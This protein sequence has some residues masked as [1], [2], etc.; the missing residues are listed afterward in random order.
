MD[1]ITIT[2]RI[3]ITLRSIANDGVRK[4][5]TDRLGV[6]CTAKLMYKSP[7]LSIDHIVKE[8]SAIDKQSKLFDNVTIVDMPS[9]PSQSHTIIFDLEVYDKANEAVW[10]VG[11]SM[12]AAPRSTIAHIA[13]L[14]HMSHAMGDRYPDKDWVK[15]GVKKVTITGAML[16]KAEKERGDVE[17]IRHVATRLEEMGCEVEEFE[18]LKYII[19]SIPDVTDC[20]VQIKHLM[21]CKDMWVPREHLDT[22]LDGVQS[23]TKCTAEERQCLMDKL[24]DPDVDGMA[25]GRVVFNMQRSCNGL[26]NGTVYGEFVHNRPELIAFCQQPP[27]TTV[28]ELPELMTKYE[29]EGKL[30]TMHIKDFEAGVARPEDIPQELFHTFVTCVKPTLTFLNKDRKCAMQMA[31]EVFCV[32]YDILR[33]VP[34]FPEMMGQVEVNFQQGHPTSPVFWIKD[35]KTI[36]STVRSLGNGTEFAVLVKL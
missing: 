28:N 20:A 34:A 5:I 6:K 33:F 14:N 22:F 4:D 15:E 9:L 24:N 36:V 3:R 18:D 19:R 32:A 13:N 10:V 21:R 31:K 25:I 2:N 7:D 16:T 35:S 23:Y 27:H 11:D 17:F 30:Y 12:P 26:A 1:G 8:Y 29:A